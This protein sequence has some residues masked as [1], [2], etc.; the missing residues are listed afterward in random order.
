MSPVASPS[1]LIDSA[2][3]HVAQVSP[4]YLRVQFDNP[5]LNLFDPEVFAGL[6]LLQ[7]YVDSAAADVRVVVFESAHP[8]F[9]FAHVDFPRVGDISAAAGGR[10]LIE[11]W[12]SFSTWLS[13][14]P[15][16]SIAKVRGRARG[17]GNEFAIACDLRFAS[18]ERAQFCQIEVGFGMVPG[19]G[20]LEWLPRHIGRAR[21]LEM[22]LGAEDIDAKTAELYGLVNRS[23]PDADLD[24][25]VDRL[26][27][28]IASFPAQSIVR[29]KALVAARQQ[30]PATDELQE[31][32]QAILQLATSEDSRAISARV[33]AKAGGSLA[34]A[35]L[36]LPDWYGPEQR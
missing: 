12:P 22:I 4:G 32:F 27:R 23:L 9:F 1:S 33:R 18:L 13:Q 34:P 5:P 19:G 25:H 8:D 6:T 2:V 35:E 11:H 14:A 21:A 36:N 28:R 20:A 31:S 16:V 29:T 17:I 7:Q 26:A 15:I 24:E 30:L 3:V 10:S